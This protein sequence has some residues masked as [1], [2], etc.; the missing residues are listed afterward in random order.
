V[1]GSPVAEGEYVKIRFPMLV[2]R[3]RKKSNIRPAFQRDHLLDPLVLP[4]ER[5]FQ[6]DLKG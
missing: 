5:R 4:K 1:A 2:L 3:L 6:V